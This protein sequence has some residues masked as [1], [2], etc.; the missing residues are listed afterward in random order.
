MSDHW[1]VL[2]PEDP[3]FVP[4]ET[5]QRLA[6]DSFAA[7]AP[8]AD[9]IDTEVSTNVAFFDCGANFERI[10]C[11]SCG[12]EIA[13]AWWQERM[14][15]DYAEGFTLSVYSTP[16]CNAKRTLHELVCDWPQGFGRFA[17]KA[18]NANIGVLDEAY[19]HEFEA[20]LGTRLRVIYR[21]N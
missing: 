13:A 3:W 12:D 14:A 15:E 10:F 19:K 11:P 9:E 6:R 21:H 16:C 7:I 8:E 17:I 4:D 1:I 20:I 5:K 2:I 18:M